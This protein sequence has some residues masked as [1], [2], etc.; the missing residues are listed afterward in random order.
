[1]RTLVSLLLVAVAAALVGSHYWQAGSDRPKFRTLS[2]TRGD[3]LIS[4][5]ATGTVE[6]VD[7]ID[8]GAQIIGI[9]TEFGPDRER[10]GKTIDYRSRVK[11][12]DVLARLDDLTKRAEADKARAS[13]KLAEAELSINRT[14]ESQTERDFQRSQKVRETLSATEYD[15][16]LF[17]YETAKAQVEASEAKVEQSKILLKQ[18]EIDLGYTTIISPVDGVVID[19]RVN[20]GQT[21]VS[22]LAAPTLFLIAKDLSKMLVWAAVNEA[23]IGDIYIGQRVSFKVDA[24][25]DLTFHGV[26]SQIRLNATNVQGVVTYGVVVDVDNTDGKLLPYMTA[27]LQFEVARRNDVVLVP[28]QALRWRPTWEHITPAERAR[29]KQPSAPATRSASSEEE[30]DLGLN[31]VEVATPTVWVVAA[32]GFVRPLPVTVGVSDGMNTEITGGELK[33]GDQVVISVVQE[34]KPDFV[35]SFVNRV[36]KKNKN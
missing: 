20:I 18:A 29:F 17:A 32:D 28:N 25:R 16:S 6:P 19:R 36:T 13:L 5:G 2:I 31:R 26:A 34:A 7:I 4:V 27:K 30:E 21:V 11:K 24:F 9:V 22:G 8:V 33:A 14:K 15:T 23:D 3:M 10:E 12:G 1:M 35:S